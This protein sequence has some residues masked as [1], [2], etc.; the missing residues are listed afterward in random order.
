MFFR[1]E[2]EEKDG[3]ATVP[4]AVRVVGEYGPKNPNAGCARTIDAV[5]TTSAIA[6]VVLV[7]VLPGIKNFIVSPERG[8]YISRD[9]KAT[10]Y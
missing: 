2:E 5:T 8:R 4:A 1:E 3:G 7:V 10:L 9:D 6:V